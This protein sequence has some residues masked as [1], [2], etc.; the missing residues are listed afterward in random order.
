LEPISRD[1]LLEAA[2]L[3]ARHRLRT[4]DA[5]QIATGLKIGA[6]WLSPTMRLG[7]VFASSKP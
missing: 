3:R 1:I 7:A 6:T 2:G 5:I 4:P